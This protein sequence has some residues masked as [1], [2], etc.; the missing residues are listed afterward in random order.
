MVAAVR[1]PFVYGGSAVG[2]G[3]VVWHVGKCLIAVGRKPIRPMQEEY[4][5]VN[6]W[7]REWCNPARSWRAAPFDDATPPRIM[8]DSTECRSI[9]VAELQGSTSVRSVP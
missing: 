3:R 4:C 2:A 6:R 1:R 9:E 7:L 5:P 8:D